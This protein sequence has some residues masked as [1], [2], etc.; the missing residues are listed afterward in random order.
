MT[1]GRRRKSQRLLKDGGR[2]CILLSREVKNEYHTREYRT[3]SVVR[4]KKVVVDVVF[5]ILTCVVVSERWKSRREL[6]YWH[7]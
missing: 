4:W 3:H 7:K 1:Y 5:V 6:M 2:S